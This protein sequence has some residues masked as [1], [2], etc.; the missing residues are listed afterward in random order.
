MKFLKINYI[1][2]VYI[3]WSFLNQKENKKCLCNYF[4]INQ[5]N[6]EIRIFIINYYKN[7]FISVKYP[8]K[9]KK[10]LQLKDF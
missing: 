4:L 9:I 2:M 1:S 10:L 5:N 6:H 7:I 8:P 3:F